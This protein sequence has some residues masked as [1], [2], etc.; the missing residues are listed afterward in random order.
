MKIR[1]QFR[2]YPT[3]EQ[4]QKLARVFGTCRFVYNWALKLR[5]DSYNNGIRIY[6]KETC[7]AL[8]MLKKTKGF[9]WLYEISSVP[10]QQSLR[11][12]QSAYKNFFEKRAG[13]PQFKKKKGS[14]GAAYTRNAFKY[15]SITKNLTISGLGRLKVRW[16][17]Q[18]ESEPSTVTITK[19]TA[20]RYFASLVLDET[21]NPWPKTGENVGVDLGITH[22]ATL[23]TGE[24][25][26]NP[27][28]LRRVEKRL[29]RAQKALSIKTKGSNRRE[30]QRLRVAK[31]HARVAD[32]RKD[33]LQKITTDL[34]RRFD[35]IAIEDLTVKGML[36]NHKLAKAIVDVGF[37]SIRGMLEYKC[38]W[39]GKDLLFCDRFFPSSK[40]CSVC[41]TIKQGMTLAGRAWVCPECVTYHDRDQNAAIN[42]L[43]AGQAA[44]ARGEVVRRRRVSSR[45]RSS[46]R[47]VNHPNGE[48]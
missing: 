47:N 19:D 11:H 7:S 35:Q 37:G 1:Y 42:I 31:L 3:K 39:Y 23:S 41:G 9:E 10:Q 24:K 27:R 32:C 29:K 15:C 48:A 28:H 16:S 2:V 8:T 30:K 46:R 14:Q 13:Y 36:K 22:L 6:F 43:A 18:F 34:V 21:K 26:Q 25:I 44:S 17:R 12:L 33:Y 38:D 4:E 45:G 5:K 40:M 20:G